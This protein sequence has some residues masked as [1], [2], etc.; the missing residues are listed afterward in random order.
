MNKY[1][2]IKVFNLNQNSLQKGGASLAV[3]EENNK[4]LLVL[5]YAQ[6]R[7]G[8]PPYVKFFEDNI[9]NDSLN[10][11]DVDLVGLQQEE[12]DLYHEE[13]KTR[14]N[15]KVNVK[16]EYINKFEGF[17]YLYDIIIEEHCPKKQDDNNISTFMLDL[18]TIKN[19]INNLLKPGG[20]F[21]I[22]WRPPNPFDNNT[23]SYLDYLTRS[24][25][26]DLVEINQIRVPF[27]FNRQF[28]IILKKNEKPVNDFLL[29][30]RVVGEENKTNQVLDNACNIYGY[31]KVISGLILCHPDNVYHIH[32]MNIYMTQITEFLF[33]VRKK[34]EIITFKT[35]DILSPLKARI[36]DP[37]VMMGSDYQADI[38]AKDDKKKSLK[39]ALNNTTKQSINL[40]GCFDIVFS[41]DCAGMHLPWAYATGYSKFHPNNIYHD[42][43]EWKFL[44]DEYIM[45]HM[46]L[47]NLD[48]IPA[49]IDLLKTDI[50]L[51]NY[52]DELD[53]QVLGSYLKLLKNNGFLV[54]GKYD[55]KLPIRLNLIKDKFE[56][57]FVEITKGNP[58]YDNF[59]ENSKSPLIVITKKN[60]KDR[61]FQ[62]EYI[63]ELT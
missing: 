26:K 23:N 38:F 52:Y 11:Y 21:I 34:K 31:S 53:K 3:E 43:S 12:L 13:K 28:Y 37:K 42:G 29:T 36:Y 39:N 54:I 56:I 32:S 35:L 46:Q 51:T 47:K 6:R 1:I 60:N 4:K 30:H 61:L 58:I 27:N 2:K 48:F 5:C 59:K 45:Q 63:K 24:D 19:F 49:Y 62:I 55:D 15:I 16:K 14:H 9:K 20:L 8:E 44:S 25:I 40:H 22:K 33:P 18:I 41:P 50:N 10:N 7:R 57:E 17:G